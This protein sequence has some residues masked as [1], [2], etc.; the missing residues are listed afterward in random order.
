M[1]ATLGFAGKV[2]VVTGAGSGLGR[3]LCKSFCAAGATVI[4]LGRS[5]PRLQET[6]DYVANASYSCFALDVSDATQVRKGMD[7]IIS[8]F[9]RVDVLFNNAAVYPRLGFMDESPEMFRQVIDINVTGVAVMCKA[10]LPH[11]IAQGYGRIFNVGSWADKNPIPKSAAYSASKGAIH[12]LTKGISADVAP[13]GLDI[14]VHE[15]IPAHMNTSMSDFTGMHPG[16]P[17][18]WA[19]DIA[20]RV[21]PTHSSKIYEGREVWQP[22]KRLVGRIKSKL[23]FWKRS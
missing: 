22:P 21:H 12:A 18:S 2:V 10:V 16:I 23:R 15:W 9:H 1:S 5:M 14:E 20:T 7:T 8:R 17:A 13:L 19:L 11:M 6:S 4:G 3:E